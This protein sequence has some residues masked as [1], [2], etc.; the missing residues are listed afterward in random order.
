[1]DTTI[2]LWMAAAVTYSGFMVFTMRS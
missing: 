2:W 1:M